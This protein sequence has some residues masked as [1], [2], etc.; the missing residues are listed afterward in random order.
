MSQI[1]FNFEKWFYSLN[2]GKYIYDKPE[3][4]D[5]ELATNKELDLSSYYNSYTLFI[6]NLGS[7]NKDKNEKYFVEV[8][9]PRTDTDISTDF[10]VYPFCNSGNSITD[11]KMSLNINGNILPING[12][13]KI[14]NACTKYTELKIRLTFEN[15]I[16][17]VRVKYLSHLFRNYL[18]AELM[19]KKFI[20]DGIKYSEGV[21]YFVN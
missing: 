16:F 10:I 11:V 14:V 4:C 12:D 13:T 18:R 17:D 6:N 5:L 8:V 19:R 15:D 1:D 2:S 9:L 3:E 20:Q 7:I 21:A